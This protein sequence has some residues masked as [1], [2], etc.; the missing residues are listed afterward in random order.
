MLS[1]TYKHFMLSV[2][3]LDV[4]ML[5]VVRLSVVRLSVVRLS[6]VAA[7]KSTLLAF[8]AVAGIKPLPL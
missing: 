6:V 2:V 4:V 7:Q 1:V 8:T 5:S 3:V